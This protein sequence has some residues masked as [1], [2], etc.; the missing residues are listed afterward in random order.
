M[1]EQPFDLE[2]FLQNFRREFGNPAKLFVPFIAIILMIAGVTSYYTVQPDEQA[3]IIRLG[4]Y[5]LTNGPG[6]HFKLPFGID[7]LELVK[8]T[9]IF[10][11]EFG[12][13]TQDTRQMRTRYA[14][15]NL[16]DEASM[17]TGDLNVADVEWVVQYR[18]NDPYK[19][20]YA[21]T[22]P[23]QT[24]RDVSESIMRRVVGDELVGD[25][26]TIG[27]AKIA[28]AAKELM[29]E[30]LDRYDLGIYITSVKLQDVNP[31]ESVKP[32]FNEVNKARQEQ[33]KMINQAEEA[34]NKVIPEARG[35][36][37]ELISTS[38]GYALALV[39]RAQG[40]SGRFLSVYNEYKD[41]PNVTR[42]RIYIET[43]RDVFKQFKNLIIV[44]DQ[45]K[46]LLP[47]F[48][49]AIKGAK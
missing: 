22:Q 32:S 28:I 7:Q 21:S 26:L 25:V 46:G 1:Q 48:N 12:F 45:I 30:I 6:L 41:A 5:H 42:K 47:I 19:F 2:R 33:E 9:K 36:A 44:D 34:Y 11:E 8:T 24:V 17:L 3:V 35:K 18:I 16:K 38:E 29:Q 4:R 49:Q 15:N 20:L 10:Q 39:N 31:P 23:I 13:R 14:S 27:R 40:D 43:M 37:D